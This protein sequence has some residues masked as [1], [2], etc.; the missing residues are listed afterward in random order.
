MTE[1]VQMIANDFNLNLGQMDDTYHKIASKV[2]DNQTLF[3][4]IQNALDDTL[5]NRNEIYVL[6]DDFGKLRLSYVKFLSVGLVIDAETAETFDYSSSIDGETYNRI[7]L[8]RENE[9]TGKRDVY[10]AQSGEN[11]NNWG[12][13]QY[14][15]TVD[16]NEN[17]QAKADSLLKL[18]NQKTKGLKINGVLGDL[19][20]RAGSLVIVQ[21]DLDDTKVNNFMLVEKVTHSFENNHHSMDLTLKGA[22]MFDG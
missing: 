12:V 14:F 3:D 4:I 19:R 17:A 22:G 11:M 7:K 13:L 15:D 21:L 1:L 9:D 8:V 2:E 5:M 6:Y 20:V 16:E 10:I 18:Y